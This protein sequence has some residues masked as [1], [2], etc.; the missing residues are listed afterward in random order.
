MAAPKDWAALLGSDRETDERT[1]A[2]RARVLARTLGYLEAYFADP[3]GERPSEAQMLELGQFL[4][5]ADGMEGKSR[6]GK[7]KDLYDEVVQLHLH[8]DEMDRAAAFS[9][10]A[11]KVALFKGA[12]AFSDAWLGTETPIPARRPAREPAPLFDD[13]DIKTRIV[14]PSQLRP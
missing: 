12:L 3:D 2:A 1:M 9:A 7:F 5:L 6:S 11:G 8:W 10:I 13:T 4:L 14:R